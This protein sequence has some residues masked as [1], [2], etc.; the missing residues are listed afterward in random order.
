[1]RKV[2]RF[3]TAAKEAVAQRRFEDAI[4]AF[5]G[6]IEAAELPAHAPLYAALLALA[7]T[8]HSL[9]GLCL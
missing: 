1:M 2:E 5:S 6:A 4:E 9:H 8:H 7:L 3:A